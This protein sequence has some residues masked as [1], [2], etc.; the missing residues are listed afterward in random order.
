MEL[1]CHSHPMTRGVLHARN[2]LLFS[3]GEAFYVWI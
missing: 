3:Q 2:V 1:S